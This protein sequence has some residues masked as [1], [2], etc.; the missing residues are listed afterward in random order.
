MKAKER[1]LYYDLLNIS[2]CFAVICLHCNGNSYRFIPTIGWAQALSAEVLFYWA[3]PVFFML[4]GATLMGYREKYSTKTFFKRRGL[5]TFVPFVLWTLINIAFKQA[6]GLMD[7]TKMGRRELIDQ[8]VNTSVEGIYWFFIPL[9]GI[10]LCMPLLSLLKDYTKTLWYAVTVSF[11]LQGVLPYVFQWLKLTWNSKLTL[12]AASG[13]V[14]YALLGYLLSVTNLSKK[15]RIVL[16]LLGAGCAA[17]RYAAT[18]LLSYKSGITD[19]TYYS[20]HG[21]FAVFLA[22]AVFVLHI[23]MNSWPVRIFGPFAIYG[24]CLLFTWIIKKIPLL[25]KIMP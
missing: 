23:D 8:C 16:Y 11:L 15:Q 18:Y 14:L 12:P 3:V 21:F 7:V 5:R 25:K 24:I 1:I 17:F 19:T 2:A 6:I 9:F 13:Y 20:Y 22:A 10:Y 4:T